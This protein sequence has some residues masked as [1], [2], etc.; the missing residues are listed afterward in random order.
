MNDRICPHCGSNR[1]YTNVYE[2]KSKHSQG[3]V[4]V[5]ETRCDR[6]MHVLDSVAHIH[7]V[8][9]KD[10]DTDDYERSCSE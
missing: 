7:E 8:I 6:C 5:E 2:R 9:A 4:V 3:W 10:G 1:V